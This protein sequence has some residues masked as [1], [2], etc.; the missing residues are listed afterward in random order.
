MKGV[1]VSLKNNIIPR[2]ITGK[3]SLVLAAGGALSLMLT[4]ACLAYL[5]PTEHYRINTLD[6]EHLLLGNDKFC[7]L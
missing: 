3:K 4:V 1:E 7:V 5:L 6:V 2:R